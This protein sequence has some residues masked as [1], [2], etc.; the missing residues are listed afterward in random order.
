[1]DASGCLMPRPI[2]PNKEIEAAVAEALTMGWR[3]VHSNGH[4]SRTFAL[5]GGFPKRVLDVGLVDA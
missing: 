4:A 5:S 2:H 1:M 3:Y